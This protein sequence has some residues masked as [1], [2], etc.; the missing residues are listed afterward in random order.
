MPRAW[1]ELE[2][3]QAVDF[4]CLAG[5]GGKLGKPGVSFGGGEKGGLCWGGGR[6]GRS[7]CLPM[8]PE[9]GGGGWEG[10]GR[11]GRGG[12]SASDM[13]GLATEDNE[14]GKQLVM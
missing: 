4:T 12:A 2:S 3:T 11:E 5:L 8:S 7:G 14:R 13:G 1:Q 6:L 9:L 10:G